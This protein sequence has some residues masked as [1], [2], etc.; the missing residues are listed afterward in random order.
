MTDPPGHAGARQRRANWV[1]L[2]TLRQ[3]PKRV[4]VSADGEPIYE[5]R[6]VR[7][8]LQ[9]MS[10]HFDQLVP[11]ARCGTEVASAPVLTPADL[12]RAPHP[13]VCTKCVSAAGVSSVR[14]PGVRRPAR[15]R[16]AARPATPSREKPQQGAER[17]SSVTTAD[18]ATVDSLRHDVRK[19]A[20][21]VEGLA[22]HVKTDQA[23]AIAAVRADVASGA[24]ERAA[25]VAR[26][27]A[28]LRRALAE[29]AALVQ[30]QRDDMASVVAAINRMQSDVQ[31]LAQAHQQLAGAQQQ[32]ERGMAA[33]AP[34]DVPALH[35]QVTQW[36]EEVER[37]LS[38]AQTTWV[39]QFDAVRAQVAEVS[40]RTEARAAPAD[41]LDGPTL[42]DQD[43]A[44]TWGSA[45]VDALDLQLRQASTRLAALSG[46]MPR[47]SSGGSGGATDTVVDIQGDAS[48]GTEAVGPAADT[49]AIP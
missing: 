9:G 43:Q 11:C 27:D 16:P 47:N 25:A 3:L 39:A 14:A 1:G 19:L 49:R 41:V 15:E 44:A 6:A 4:D 23:E 34:L 36:V 12:E 5:V 32:L 7:M 29:V 24:D 18:G 17:A 45:V 31:V 37:R 26:I 48:P 21:R 33:L 22:L 2:R 42:S 38:N 28:D 8:V 30:R 10:P 20:A 35:Q 46:A 40:A 13:A